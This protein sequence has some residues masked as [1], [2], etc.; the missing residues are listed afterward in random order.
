MGETRDDLNARLDELSRNVEELRRRLTT[1]ES[2]VG[3]TPIAASVTAALPSTGLPLEALSSDEAAAGEQL[4]AESLIPAIGWGLLGIAGAYLLRATAGA[5]T[6]AGLLGVGAG[7]LYAG[8]W[9]VFAARRAADNRMHSAIYALTAALILAPMLWET[10]VRFRLLPVES[11]SA[12]LLA[13]VLLGL[14]IAWKRNV[15]SI[16]SI[17]TLTTLGATAALFRETHDT[18][19]CVVTVLVVAAAVEFSACRD[20]WMRLRWIVAAAADLT[21][22]LVTVM[23]TIGHSPGEGIVPPSLGLVLAAQIALLTIYLSST[24]DRTIFRKLKIIRFEIGQTAVAF[25]V[26]ILGALRLA[27]IDH[28][29]AAGV[30][31]FCLTGGAACYLVSFAILERARERDHNFYAYSTFAILLT[32]AGCWVLMADSMLAGVWSLL[33]VAAICAAF[34]RDR[35]TLR[36]H[37]AVYLILAMVTAE[38]VP[39]ALGRITGTSAQAGNLPS[40]GYLLTLAGSALCYLALMRLGNRAEAHWM[41]RVEATL[42]VALVCLAAMGLAASAL[43]RFLSPAPPLRTALITAF[44][45][46]AAWAGL[47]WRRREL[48]WL[49]YPLMALSGFKLLTEDFQQGRSLTLFASLIFFGGGLIVLPRL[50]RHKSE[51]LRG[52]RT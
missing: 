25:L 50:L 8:C 37:S 45:L 4:H 29:A 23:V 11:A 10:T 1:L 52:A 33:A 19:A 27:G 32:L 49:A 26:S 39:Q 41:D 13:F 6:I 14:T 2:N 34:Q 15:S 20:R 46:G 36:V 16:A 51:N 44:A 22:L 38:L 3:L 21:V 35:D 47:R 9:L 42:S 43:Y 18:A 12:V 5:G 7:V 40:N 48:T 30:G 17:V 31:W 28:A 24:V